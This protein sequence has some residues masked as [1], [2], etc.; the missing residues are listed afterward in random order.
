[1]QPSTEPPK[2]VASHRQSIA[3]SSGTVA[4]QR[5]IRAPLAVFII[6][7][8]TLMTAFVGIVVGVLTI[9]KSRESIYDI[10]GQLRRSI[11]DRTLETVNVTLYDARN[12]LQG[13]ISDMTLYRFINNSTDPDWMSRQDIITILY[14]GAASVPY[15]EGM[16]MFY[17][18]DSSGRQTGMIVNPG[19]KEFYYQNS[20]TN[21][22]LLRHAILGTNPDYSLTLS[23]TST[24][25]RTDWVPNT[26][27]A[28]A[29][30]SFALSSRPAFSSLNFARPLGTYV[31]HLL[32]PVWKDLPVLTKGPGTYHACFTVFFSIPSI[33]R[34]LE[35]LP[36]SPNGVLALIEAQTG[37][38]LAS[39][40]P[41]ISQNGTSDLR[42]PA[43]GN[44]NPLVSAAAA[45]LARTFGNG[46][47][48]SLPVDARRYDTA[49]KGFGDEVLVNAGWVV[50]EAQ[51]IR[52]L[53]MVV[54]P[55]DD[56]LA[57]IKSTTNHTITFVVCVCAASIVAGI[58]LSWAIT[59]P[60]MKLSHAMKEATQ[61]DFSALSEGYLKHRSVVSEIGRLQGVFNEM[62]VKFAGAIRANKSLVVGGTGTG[63]RKGS[64][65][66]GGGPE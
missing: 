50:D 57:T 12:T 61:F 62:M 26:I 54:I 33:S 64:N 60:L 18:P 38:M 65:V 36:V 9:N 48:Q 10:T 22:T 66:N 17:R 58:V 5:K 39:S 14:N 1:M 53:L 52:W 24:V 7:V 2:P 29:I 40:V 37:L 35:T 16:V 46:T 4:A 45:Y 31:V 13:K 21:Y 41:G 3:S 8:V 20:T 51:S 63:P 30:A 56:F 34:F 23:P 49:F 42:F 19:R 25:S 55:S 47:L 59:A 6:I 43:I 11:L 28:D 44:P 15:L 27:Y 32:W